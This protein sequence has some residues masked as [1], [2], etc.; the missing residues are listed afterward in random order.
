MPVNRDN[1]MT[2]HLANQIRQMLRDAMTEQGIT[3]KELGKRLNIGG[4]SVGRLLHNDGD[5][6]LS[7]VILA[8]RAL[9][10]RFE[11]SLQPI[12]KNDSTAKLIAN[13]TSVT[14]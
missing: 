3:A 7:T 14:K 8:A 11:F 9:T 2:H 6:L 12:T 10:M 5:I 13:T 4:S 1:A